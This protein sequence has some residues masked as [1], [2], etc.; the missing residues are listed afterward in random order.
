MLNIKFVVRL[1]AKSMSYLSAG[2]YKKL[3]VFRDPKN[4]VYFYDLSGATLR[5]MK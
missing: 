3:M 4:T 5:R 2:T 1:D